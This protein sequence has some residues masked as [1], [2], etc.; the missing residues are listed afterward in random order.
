MI[1]AVVLFLFFL[2]IGGFVLLLSTDR[3]MPH[4]RNPVRVVLV[5]PPAAAEKPPPPEKERTPQPPV[6]ENQTI[7]P[8]QG[9]MQPW[10]RG[11][12]KGDDKPAAEGPLGVEGEGGAGSD[13]FGLVGRGKGGREI[14]TLGSGPAGTIGGDRAS[15]MKKYGGYYRLLREEMQKGINKRL[16]GEKAI[17]KGRLEILVWLSI[18]DGGGISEY[19]VTRSSGSEAMDEAVREYLSHARMQAPPPGMPRDVSV[20][21]TY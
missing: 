6:P 13:A 11:N 1:T 7:I 9:P 14:T 17:P 10:E 19:R 16:E 4:E 5:R 21:F 2:A 8:P 18:E 20:R 3:E 12:P 15:A